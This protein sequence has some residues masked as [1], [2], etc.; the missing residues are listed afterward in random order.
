MITNEQ[1]EHAVTCWFALGITFL[2]C[3]CGTLLGQTRGG[4]A[5]G[6]ELF[7]DS[8]NNYLMIVDWDTQLVVRRGLTGNGGRIFNAQ[9]ILAPNK[10]YRIW[11]FNPRERLLG[12]S[13]VGTPNAGERGR[14]V[15]LCLDTEIGM[16]GNGVACLRMIK[17]QLGVEL[18]PL[19]D[20][21]HRCMM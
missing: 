10:C 8:R 12:W 21:D 20:Q 6:V 13:E 16:D 2:T 3:E 11:I 18:F 1:V 17:S 5:L 19:G 4:R 9:T 14:M 7:V 15:H